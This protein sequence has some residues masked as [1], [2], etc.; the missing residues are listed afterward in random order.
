[1]VGFLVAVLQLRWEPPEL[2]REN[3]HWG[4]Q[5]AGQN[6][7]DLMWPCLSMIVGYCWYIPDCCWLLLVRSL[8]ITQW[9]S[10]LGFMIGEHDSS[11]PEQAKQLQCCKGLLHINLIVIWRWLRNMRP[12]CCFV[13]DVN[14]VLL[15]CFYCNVS[16]WYPRELYSGASNKCILLYHTLSKLVRVLQMHFFLRC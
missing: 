2:L 1:M 14:Q 12:Q 7:G 5:Q 10:T 11:S 6:H 8:M 3:I 15:W 9:W 16:W 4:Y 13:L